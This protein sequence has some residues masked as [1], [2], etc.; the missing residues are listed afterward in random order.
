[1]GPGAAGIL[2]SRPERLARTHGP[3]LPRASP[4]PEGARVRGEGRLGVFDGFT[5]KS[6]SALGVELDR[7]GRLRALLGQVPAHLG[8]QRRLLP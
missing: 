6:Q 5:E 8:A 7:G 4:E 2:A 3:R 1:M